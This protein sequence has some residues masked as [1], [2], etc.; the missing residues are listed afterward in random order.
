ME[1]LIWII[2]GYF[3]GSILFGYLVPKLFLN[4]DVRKIS[5]DGNPGTYNAMMYGGKKIGILVA[6]LD[7]LKGMI[8]VM[9]ARQ[10]LNVANPLFSLVVAAPCIGHGYSIFSKF[11]GGKCLGISYGL[12]L[13]LLPERL[14]LL[15]LCFSFLFYNYIAVITPHF[16]R[17]IAIYSTVSIFVIFS[18]VVLGIKLGVILVCLIVIRKHIHSMKGLQFKINWFNKA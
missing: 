7:V 18:H 17:S 14:P 12:M 8:P 11:K 2:I 15:L 10:F 9:V 5:K 4:I 16:C 3:S 13:G 6:A 1:Y